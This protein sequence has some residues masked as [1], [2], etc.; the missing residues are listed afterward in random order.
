MIFLDFLYNVIDISYHD[1]PTLYTEIIC[2]KIR[3]E[4]LKEIFLD[5]IKYF[6]RIKFCFL[7]DRLHEKYRSSLN[8]LLFFF[9]FMR[10]AFYF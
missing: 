1:N 2:Y 6:S 10:G 7:F 8:F 5:K 3:Y 9:T 4:Y